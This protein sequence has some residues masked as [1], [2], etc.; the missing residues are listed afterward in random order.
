MRGRSSTALMMLKTA[1]LVL[2]LSASVRM[3]M[4]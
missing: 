2:I 1:A 4:R 3:A